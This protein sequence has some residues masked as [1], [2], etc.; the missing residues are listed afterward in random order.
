VPWPHQTAEPCLLKIILGRTNLY[1]AY[2]HKVP[3][4]PNTCAFHFIT[5]KILQHI[6]T[7]EYYERKLLLQVLPN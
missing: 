3:V 2:F 7:T 1:D 5:A 4:H 6:A